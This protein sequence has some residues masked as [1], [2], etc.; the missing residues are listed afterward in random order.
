MVVTDHKPLVKILGDRT[1]HEITNTRL[2]RLK[3]RTLPWS[4][5]IAHLPGKTNHAADATSRNPSASLNDYSD[6]VSYSLRPID[7]EVE[8]C[9][10]SA[11]SDDV[12]SAFALSWS[13]IKSATR[14]STGYCFMWKTGSQRQ[15]TTYQAI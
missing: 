3:Q 12:T 1:L 8:E 14:L 5:S 7:G 11:I 13:E 15:E 2:F 6:E 10:V 4:F 9:H